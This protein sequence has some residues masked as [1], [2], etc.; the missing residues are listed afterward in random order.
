MLRKFYERYAE[1]ALTYGIN[2]QKDGKLEI[3]CPTE[4]EE[5]GLIIAEKAYIKGAKM[6]NITWDNQHLDAL[7]YKY[8]KKDELIKIPD[9]FVAK[10]NS[11][12]DDNACYIAI[13]A[14][15][16]LIF[17][18]LD[19]EKIE[20]MKGVFPCRSQKNNMA[21]PIIRLYGKAPTSSTKMHAAENR[22]SSITALEK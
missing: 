13:D 8:A 17:N 1:L 18:G 7:T 16:P 6:V 21:F 3:L 20:K 22:N 15:Y 14:D 10:K 5:F 12:I 4:C 11:L 2:L 9:W 19:E